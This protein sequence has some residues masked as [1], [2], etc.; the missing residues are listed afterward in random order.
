MKPRSLTADEPSDIKETMNAADIQFVSIA[1]GK[2]VD[3]ENKKD[4]IRIGDCK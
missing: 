2:R 4:D 3:I 1:S